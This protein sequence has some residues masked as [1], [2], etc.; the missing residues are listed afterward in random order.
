MAADQFDSSPPNTTM[1]PPIEPGELGTSQFPSAWP[2]VIGIVIIVLASFSVLGGIWALLMPFLMESLQASMPPA[3]RAQMATSMERTASAVMSMLLY[4]VL[5]GALFVTGIGL[6]RRRQW[7]I[8]FCRYWSFAKIVVVLGT[9]LLWF[10]EYPE[11]MRKMQEMQQAS[12]TSGMPVWSYEAIGFV[13]L[14]FGLIWGC[15][16]PVFLLIWLGRR[17]INQE[18]AAWG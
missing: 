14:A 18:V 11:N 6:V 7:S 8:R 2:K 3:Q 4:M 15:A 1:A 9:S 10:V 5:G 17:K 13:G 12:G 16:L